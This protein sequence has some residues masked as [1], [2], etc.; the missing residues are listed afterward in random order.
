MRNA[1][2]IIVSFD[3]QRAVRIRDGA[4]LIAVP[5]EC[6]WGHWACTGCEAQSW[7]AV[8]GCDT[9]KAHASRHCHSDD[10]KDHTPIS[11]RLDLKEAVKR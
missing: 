3:E 6:N 4:R 5:V 8:R 11:W 7:P 1:N 9:A 10:R 2:E